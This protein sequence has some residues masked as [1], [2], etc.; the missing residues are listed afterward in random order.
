MRK[1]VLIL[2]TTAALLVAPLAH[3]GGSTQKK[4][5]MYS[6]EISG[7]WTYNDVI[8]ILRAELFRLGWTTQDVQDIDF[9]LRD[10]RRLVH[11]K[12]LQVSN[13]KLVGELIDKHPR[14]S[15]AVSQQIVVYQTKP[16]RPLSYRA[17]P[18]EI[19]IGALDPGVT[20]DAMGLEADAAVAAIR[21]DI[22]SALAATVAFF[23]KPAE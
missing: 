20:A 11:N 23:S 10:E 8:D 5:D 1:S 13:P 17:Q 14:A 3:A 2:L 6:A 16:E 19:T 21:K 7:M 12:V 18:G 9:T 15:L 4:G 22:E